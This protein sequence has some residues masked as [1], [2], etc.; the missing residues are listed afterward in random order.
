[1]GYISASVFL[2]DKQNG[3]TFHRFAMERCKT[4]ATSLVMS[5]INWEMKRFSGKMTLEFQLF[6]K[7]RQ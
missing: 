6:I 5:V 1:M 4:V 7:I 3:G 2:Q